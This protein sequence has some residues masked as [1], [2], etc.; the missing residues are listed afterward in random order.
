MADEEL[1]PEF[2]DSALIEVTVFVQLENAENFDKKKA[3]MF[4][5][6]KNVT[7]AGYSQKLPYTKTFKVKESCDINMLL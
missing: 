1:F 2:M 5:T 4:D 3:A 6:R 7:D